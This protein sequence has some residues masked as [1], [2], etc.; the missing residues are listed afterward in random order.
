MDR[1]ACS[2][3]GDGSV[4]GQPAVGAAIAVLVFLLPPLRANAAPVPRV[5]IP[6]LPCRGTIVRELAA[7]EAS[8]FRFNAAAGEV[9]VVDAIDLSGS[10]ELL[11]LRL[12]G[13]G[14]IN[15]G[16]TCTGRLQQRAPQAGT[17]T[18]EVKDCIG[19]DP[20]RYALTLNV[21]SDTRRSCSQ[22]LLC[23]AAAEGSLDIPG[24][25]RAFSFYGA[26]DDPVSLDL[27]STLERRGGLEVRLF[28]PAGVPVLQSC[29]NSF[30]FNLPR[31][32]RYTLLVNACL[33]KGTGEYSLRWRSRSCSTHV[34]AHSAG[35]A[36]GARLAADGTQVLQVAA[37]NLSCGFAESP[38][39]ILDLSPPLPVIGGRFSTVATPQDAIV[40]LTRNVAIDGV[41]VD[42]EGKQLLGGMSIVVGR[43][44]CN[45]QW[46]ATSTADTDWDGWSDKI[47][48]QL[49]ADPEDDG[50]RPEDRRLPTTALF[51]PGVCRDRH[52]NDGDG[53]V[54]AGDSG[55][56]GPLPSAPWT[57]TAYAGRHSGGGALAI[58]TSPG[59]ARVTR[60]MTSAIS[61]GTLPSRP[62]SLD[63]DIPIVR[64]RFLFRN[65]PVADVLDG[66]TAAAITIDGVLFDGDGDG[67]PDQ[68]LGNVLVH[69]DGECRYRWYASAHVD[70]DGDGW[71]DVAERRL[72]SDERPL[73]A[74]LGGDSV[75]ESAA[76]P[77]AELDEFGP[78]NDGV[79]NDRNGLTDGED[80]KCPP[81][82]PT[83]TRTATVTFTST[84]TLTPTRMAT[85]TPTPAPTTSATASPTE[86][87]SVRATAAPTATST[88]GPSHTPTRT[89]PAT[90]TASGT[91][92]HTPAPPTGTASATV[93][94]TVEPTATPVSPT[95]SPPPCAGD[96][97]GDRAVTVDE[98]VNLVQIGLGAATVDGCAAGDLDGSG[99]ITVD[100]IL[101]AV[102]VAL[103]GC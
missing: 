102:N 98:I 17:Y 3:S 77:L 41:V 79:D 66:P 90:P 83:A 92:S 99:G 46:A 94:G 85:R 63:V 13:P 68:A 7:G 45:F 18:L 87:G 50:S 37:S 5:A 27:H 25:V 62:V 4:H 20:G 58:E 75:P 80:P 6:E 101:A 88:G 78:C 60:L 15:L 21:I 36:V 95:P 24:E 16:N 34:G 11:R 67:T 70:S 35:G 65:L 53:L 12:T 64:N 32:G 38:G 74:G 73:P 54:D 91:P 30:D 19:S 9:F 61:C 82:T 69:S 10:I 56:S 76:V 47:E 55:C 52:D 100:E 97:D 40:N 93:T 33:G 22:S 1:R 23:G 49:G 84:P 8:S 57:V 86:T 26:R 42:D 48:E 31:T 44:R 89:L 103:G 2:R 81:P 39:F 96:C 43:A 29:G 14:G 71:G 59:G 51:G 72:G 28:D